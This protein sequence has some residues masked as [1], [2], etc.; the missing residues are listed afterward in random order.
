MTGG[1]VVG[2]LAYFSDEETEAWKVKYP[3]LVCWKLTLLPLTWIWSVPLVILVIHKP[4]DIFAF[5]KWLQ[6]RNPGLW[7]LSSA[8]SGCCSPEDSHSSFL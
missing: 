2:V 3:G 4:M 5:L 8:G 6:R 1:N 7:Q